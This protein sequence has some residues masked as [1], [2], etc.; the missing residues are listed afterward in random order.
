[1]LPQCT[2]RTCVQFLWETQKLKDVFK[3]LCWAEYHDHLNLSCKTTRFSL[4][5]INEG[6]VWHHDS[7]LTNQPDVTLTVPGIT[8]VVHLGTCCDDVVYVEYEHDLTKRTVC[9]PQ[10]AYVFPGYCISHRSAREFTF[11]KDPRAKEPRYSLVFF[12]RFK[13]EK[14][15]SMDNKIHDQFSYYNDNYEFRAANFNDFLKKV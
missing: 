12:F 10:T 4:N 13:K 15:R 9:R 14:M 7:A 11:T 2:T 8:F 6:L 5:K 3:K 1:M